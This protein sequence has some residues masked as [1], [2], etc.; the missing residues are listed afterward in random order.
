MT[1]KDDS[2]YPDGYA[3]QH[4]LTKR[5]YFAA[6]AMQGLIDKRGNAESITA[7][8]AVSYADALIKELSK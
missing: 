2:V 4:G 6:M 3:D 8:T 5:E 1:N 7:K